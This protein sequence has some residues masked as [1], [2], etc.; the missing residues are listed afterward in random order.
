MHIPTLT[1][2]ETIFYAGWS[3]IYLNNNDNNKNKSFY[4]T[5]QERVEL[6]LLLLGLTDVRNSTVGNSLI[7]GISGGQLKRL[8]IA[9][10]IFTLPGLIFLGK[11]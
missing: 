11:L 6:L 1:V 3:R 10:S 8:S 4:T 2:E 5:I 7:K 9:I